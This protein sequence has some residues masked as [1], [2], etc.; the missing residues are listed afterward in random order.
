MDFGGYCKPLLLEII[1]LKI[2]DEIYLLLIEIL[3]ISIWDPERALCSEG[4]LG[5]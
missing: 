5:F 4:S 3:F 1:W 2:L